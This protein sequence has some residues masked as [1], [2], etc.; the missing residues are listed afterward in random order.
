MKKNWESVLAWLLTTVI[1]IGSINMPVYA[2]GKVVTVLEKDT[3]ETSEDIIDIFSEEEI[4]EERVEGE[5][6][7]VSEEEETSDIEEEMS[8]ASEEETTEAFENNGWD[9][10]T[11]QQIYENENYRI[12][13]TLSSYWETG[14]NA[15]IR[16]ENIGRETIHNWCLMFEY[17]GEISNTWNG[18]IMSHEDNKYIIKNAG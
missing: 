5:T 15:N 9:G 12:I 11:T 2:Q 14:Y 8:I 10:E 7:S 4:T 16:I 18:N 13:F 3:T 17:D 1:C 6:E